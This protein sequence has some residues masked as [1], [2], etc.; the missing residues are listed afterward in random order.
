MGRT[1]FVNGRVFDGTEV[2][3]DGTNV[4]VEGNRITQVSTA[5]VETGDDDV[6]RDLGGRTLM[7]GMV[8]CHFHTGFGP[9]AGNEVLVVDLAELFIE[10]W[11][12][13]DT[14]IADEGGPHEAQLLTL[15]CE[16]ARRFLGWRA[17]LPARDAVSWSARWY[18]Q[19]FDNADQAALHGFTLQQI[20]EFCELAEAK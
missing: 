8:Q 7:P 17:V 15:S 19:W 16:K 9:D 18:R 5:P 1:V 12:D 6:V 10:A 20:D 4:V 13:G 2:L 14:K 3:A 11:G